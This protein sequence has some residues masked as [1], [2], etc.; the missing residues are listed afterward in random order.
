MRLA[1]RSN[2]ARRAGHTTVLAQA[3]AVAVGSPGAAWR[4]YP[5]VWMD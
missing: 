3:A 2:F 1:Y 4:T 5:A